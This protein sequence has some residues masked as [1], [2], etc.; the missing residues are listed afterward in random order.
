MRRQYLYDPI[1]LRLRSRLLRLHRRDPR[2]HRGNGP[3]HDETKFED[4]LVMLKYIYLLFLQVRGGP[5]AERLL[6]LPLLE[7]AS[8]KSVRERCFG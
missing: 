6:Q 3:W 2:R 5:E 4:L 7:F 8:S 1:L